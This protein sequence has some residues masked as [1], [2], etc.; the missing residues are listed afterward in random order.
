MKTKFLLVAMLLTVCGLASAQHLSCR[1]V[2]IGGARLDGGGFWNSN[3][4]FGSMG[5]CEQAVRNARNGLICLSHNDFFYSLYNTQWGEKLDSQYMDFN[6][7]VAALRKARKGLVC[8]TAVRRGTHRMIRIN[9]HAYRNFNST[10]EC[11]EA[12]DSL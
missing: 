9:D 3:I 4:V 1:S 7:C 6:S 5:H 8:A 2:M 11:Q 12:L 10:E